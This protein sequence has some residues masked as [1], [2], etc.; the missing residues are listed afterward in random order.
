MKK[1]L[2]NIIALICAISM[3]GS[4]A[5][6]AANETYIE[7][8]RDDTT[9]TATAT[10]P[11]DGEDKILVVSSYKNGLLKEIK[12]GRV[13]EAGKLSA[14]VAAGV[15][16]VIAN[17]INR[18]GGTTVSSKAVYAAE[19]L[20]ISGIKINGG[21]IADFSNDIN[22]YT[23]Q[24]D[25]G[26]AEIEVILKDSTTKVQI[27]DNIC[28]GRAK[29]ELSTY[30]GEKR[31]I[32][33]SM[34]DTEDKTYTLSNLK[35]LIGEDEYEIDNFDPNT[36]NYSVE[37]P[38]NTMNIRL[39]PETAG[40]VKTYVTDTWVSTIDGVKL[41]EIYGTA[42]DAYVYK[43]NAV[44][45][46]IP[47]KNEIATAEIRVSNGKNGK[48]EKESIYQIEFTARQ[49]RL[50]EF[51][52]T[53]CSTDSE[54]PAFVGGSAV[55]NDNGTIITTQNGWTAGNISEKLLGGSMFMFA[56]IRK[57]TWWLSKAEGDYFNFKADTPGTIYV[58]SGN[59]FDNSTEYTENGW[60]KLPGTSPTFPEWG[61]NY[62]N[63]RKDYNDWDV[64][65]FMSCL[66]YNAS[67]STDLRAINPGIAQTTVFSEAGVTNA[68]M[69]Y[70]YS[71]TFEAGE[72]VSV[73]NSGKSD[74]NA[75]SICA[76]IKWDDE[77]VKYA[78]AVIEEAEEEDI[79]LLPE[80][81]PSTEIVKTPHPDIILDVAFNEE[82]D[83]TSNVWI[84][85]SGHDN[86][87]ILDESVGQWTANGYKTESG[88]G[89]IALPSAVKNMFNT[90]N[91]TLEFEIADASFDEGSSGI[92]LFSQDGERFIIS[93]TSQ[94]QL[95]G[96]WT[97]TLQ[98]PKFDYSLLVGKK[99]TVVF[100]GENSK[101]HWYIEG[102]DAP[103]SKTMNTKNMK[104]TTINNVALGIDDSD[105]A[106]SVTFNSIKVYNK[107]LTA[108]QIT[109]VEAE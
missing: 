31:T 36:Y 102:E 83:T 4:L 49:P 74:W 24:C 23:V 48:N 99:H 27:S 40:N 43:R 106:G 78:P 69:I 26:E 22:D 104:D 6:F 47:I 97:T 52:M 107:V 66:Y 71:K 20:D 76:V 2:K 60:T 50:T 29:I 87:I 8:T 98:R 45:N 85:E 7:Y 80:L 33:V 65:Y 79:E 11:D 72:T 21:K 13:F 46:L 34:Y 55:N 96:G 93:S 42:S 90:H 62:K 58:M 16:E 94:V 59:K 64:D 91:F 86:N 92:V 105:Y 56:D 25:A 41:G 17:V 39:V 15:D 35:Y 30:R 70:G 109:G 81:T 14:T 9:I 44:N 73:F 32:T 103:I 37:L 3:L 77:Y 38:D 61:G 63:I 28:P 12:T 68:E 10:V 95:M 89:A 5:A 67:Q 51:N 75:A 19:E 101:I 100:D 82:T 57:S 84:D 108:E 1:V 18:F 88:A 53:G 54:K